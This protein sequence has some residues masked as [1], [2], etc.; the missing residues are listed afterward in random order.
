M[1]IEGAQGAHLAGD[2]GGSEARG[3]ER[4]EV[5]AHQQPVYGADGGIA[6]VEKVEE[7]AQVRAVVAQ[8]IGG[9]VLLRSQRCEVALEQ[10][11]SVDPFRAA[12][13]SRDDHDAYA[14]ASASSCSPIGPLQ[15]H[16]VQRAGVLPSLRALPPATIRPLHFGQGWASGRD[17]EV[18]SHSGYLAQP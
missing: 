14:V 17:Q 3:D 16:F 9:E 1:A 4:R 8:G 13:A 2:A 10:R 7:V 5:L 6:L 12:L 15:S 18:N 11:L